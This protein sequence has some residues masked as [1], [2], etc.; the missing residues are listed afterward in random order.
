MTGDG[1][2]R[3]L[4]G[5]PPVLRHTRDYDRRWL[6]GDIVA[7]ITLIAVLLPTGMGYAELAGLPPYTGLV[8]T[9]V[10][11]VAYAVF[12]P[13]RTLVVGPDSSLSP[14]IAAAIVPLA[15]GSDARA[16]ALAGVLAVMIGIVLL[17]AAVLRLG[18]LTDLLS[19]PIR[20]GYLNGIALTVL[21]EQLPGVLGLNRVESDGADP[22]TGFVQD[23]AAGIADWRT[24]ALGGGGLVVILLLRR[25]APRTPGALLVIL[26]AAILSA[27]LGWTAS[28]A[29]VGALPAGLPAIGIDLALLDWGDVA[30]LTPAALGIALIALADTSIL[31][32]SISERDHRLVDPRQEMIGLGLTNIA[33]GVIGGFAIGGSSSR[34]PVLRSAGGRSQLASL[35]GAAGILVFL[36]AAP[37]ATAWVPAAALSAVVVAAALALV[38]VGT[39]R[40]LFRMSPVD[41]LLCL[42]ATAGVAVAGVLTGIG[43]AVGLSI[44]ALFI[45]QWRPYRAELG[46]VPGL[47]G[48][49]DLRHPGARRIP[50]IVIVRFDAPLNFANAGTFSEF[51]RRTLERRRDRVHEVVLAAEPITGIDTTA[52]DAL[53]MLD[54]RLAE[55]DVDLVLAEMKDPVRERLRRLDL[56]GQLA[57]NMF[58]PTVGAAVDRFTGRLRSDIAAG[59]AEAGRT[60]GQSVAR[61]LGGQDATRHPDGS[62]AG[63]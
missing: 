32:R 58:E 10:G 24:L 17:L 5:W 3:A 1:A 33:V 16:I 63:E 19:K 9:V 60:G 28:I 52:V 42:T 23:V 14:M 4:P 30:A 50:G 7:G 20:V 6:R 8:A 29:T 36:F 37:A 49:H 11:L 56:A 45:E 54:R 18:V 62:T 15:L 35:I 34:T 51:V 12:G 55:T 47:R 61:H 26:M 44:L 43:I 46:L 59:R 21:A 31:S 22:F 38:D 57:D 41:G 48:Y 39:V 25:L 13:S 2:H 53:I 40:R 27:G